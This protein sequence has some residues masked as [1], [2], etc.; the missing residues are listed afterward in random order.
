MHTLGS[1]IISSF[2][3]RDWGFCGDM[4]I[5]IFPE[6]IYHIPWPTKLISRGASGD[7][8]RN[9]GSKVTMTRQDL[10]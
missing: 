4:F 3:P 7:S 10:A 9:C 6:G 1:D 5:E 2:L 8:K